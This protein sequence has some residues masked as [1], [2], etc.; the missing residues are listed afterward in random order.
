M[1]VT[2]TVL[3]GVNNIFTLRTSESDPREVE[4]RIKGKIL[5][6][7]E[8]EHS[9]LAPGDFV[10]LEISP[11]GNRIVARRKRRNRVFRWN[12]KRQKPQTI[13]ANVDQ[14]L[15]VA[16]ITQPSIRPRFIDRVLAMA[17][18]E[19]V[20]AGVVVNKTDLSA[21][22]P[23]IRHYLSSLETLGY[24]VYPLSAKTGEGVSAIRETMKNRI[25]VLMGQS[26]VGK[27]TLI[28][29]IFPDAKLQTGSIS[30]RFNRGRHTTTRAQKILAQDGIILIDTP[31]VREF[32]L[33]AYDATE[34]AAGFREIR[35]YLP[36]CRMP[37]CT[38]THE[39]GCA[40]LNALAEG[41]I[42]DIRYESY[43]RIIEDLDHQRVPR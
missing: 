27:S 43:L 4:A 39:P 25:S 21:P 3:W 31:G 24:E 37:S 9:P 38:H 22:S 18:L 28:N 42:D 32:D 33:F 29:T 26:G 15:V 11:E 1:T 19:T 16:S 13:A 8:D 6:L 14:V 23:E 36:D 20:P 40:V 17:E 10:D 7:D 5:P 2:A 34:I 30:H 35:K 12:N 41:E